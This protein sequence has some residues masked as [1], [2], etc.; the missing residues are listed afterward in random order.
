MFDRNV[1]T[2]RRPL[3]KTPCKPSAGNLA[4]VI[5]VVKEARCDRIST[6]VAF[7]RLAVAMGTAI[8]GEVRFDNAARAAYA[9]DASNYRQ[10]PIGVVLPRT[11]EDVVASV[12]LCREHGAAIL[13]R[14]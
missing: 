13:P 8:A 7:Q 11:V 3:F 2:T 9:S 6:M 14:G 12:A 4:P 5:V 10:V 1:M